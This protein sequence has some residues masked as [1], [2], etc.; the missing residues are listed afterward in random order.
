M[1]LHVLPSGPQPVGHGQQHEWLAKLGDGDVRSTH[2][3]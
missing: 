1:E 2:P 3:L